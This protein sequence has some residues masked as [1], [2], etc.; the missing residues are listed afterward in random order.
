MINDI[1]ITLILWLP[2]DSLDT[3][4]NFLDMFFSKKAQPTLIHRTSITTIEYVLFGPNGQRIFSG[5]LVVEA[6]SVIET[7]LQDHTN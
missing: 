6:A 3:A 4:L 5:D 1:L 7:N 2:A